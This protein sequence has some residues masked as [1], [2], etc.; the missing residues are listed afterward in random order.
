MDCGDISVHLWASLITILTGCVPAD[1]ASL[2]R[3]DGQYETM[4]E[5]FRRK[6][7]STRNMLL[8]VDPIRAYQ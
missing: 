8:T 5:I 6:R 1:L 4:M 2:G 7:Y 3:T